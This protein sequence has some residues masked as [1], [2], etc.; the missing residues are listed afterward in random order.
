MAYDIV[1]IGGGPGGYVAAI[2]AAQMGARVA[3]VEKDRLGGT[4]LNRGCIPTK[5]L[6]AGA[7]LVRQ[8]ED[9]ASFGIEVTGLRV[10]FRRLQERKNGV[11]NQLVGGIEFLF[12]KQKVEHIR[13][14]GKLDGP[15]RVTV[16]LPGGTREELLAKAVII[17]TG[18]EPALI[19]ALG[20]DGV[21]VVTSNEAL[22][23]EDVPESLLVIGGGVI[24]CEFATLFGTLGS[25]VTVVEALPNILPPVDKEIARKQQS[26]FKQ[27]GVEVK[28]KATITSVRQEGGQVVA[29]LADGSEV[30]AQK[31]LISIG[32]RLNTQGLG[33]AE[34]GVALGQRGEILVDE[35][36]STS[37]PGLYAIGDVTNKVQ[38]AHVASAQGLRAV[39]NILG[40]RRAMDYSV[41]PNCIFTLPEIAGVGLTSQEAEARGLKTRAGKFPFQASGKALAAGEAEGMVKVLA[42]EESGRLLGVHILGPHATDLIAEAALALKHG[43]T[44]R[45]LAETMHAHPTLPEAVAEAAEAVYGR[46]IHS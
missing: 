35:L 13:G 25:R 36:L 28:T 38:L 18:S 27:R 43:L 26:L 32:R 7:A 33:L 20:Y 40:E 45:E 30:R 2:R 44:A 16:T 17:A 31:A 39:E 9:A 46:S 37:V 8:I 41:V 3:V 10:D 12:K 34:A 29:A 42:E 19:E 14:E 22:Q 24:G 23:W 6:L 1:I 15:G 21:N 4:C 5:A 11:V